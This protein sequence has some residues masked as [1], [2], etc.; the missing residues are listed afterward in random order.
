MC[1]TNTLSQNISMSNPT[2]IGISLGIIRNSAKHIS[3]EYKFRN[4][5]I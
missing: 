3:I 5:T 1:N 4:I 2:W